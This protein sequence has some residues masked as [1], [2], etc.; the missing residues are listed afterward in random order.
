[1]PSK[2]Q[3]RPVS[4]VKEALGWIGVLFIL[5]AY[6]LITLHILDARSLVYGL[7]N[8]LGAIGIIVSSYFKRDFQPVILNAVWLAVAIIGIISSFS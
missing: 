4:F 7:L 1:M 5:S 3:P 8:A 2:E 6:T